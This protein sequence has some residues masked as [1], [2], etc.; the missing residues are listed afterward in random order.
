M[1]SRA[2]QI[3]FRCQTYQRVQPNTFLTFVIQ[4]FLLY[5]YQASLSVGIKWVNR[6]KLLRRYQTHSM[7]YN[8]YHGTASFLFCSYLLLLS[9]FFYYYSYISIHCGAINADIYIIHVLSQV[10]F[11]LDLDFVS[12]FEWRKHKPCEGSGNWLLYAAAWWD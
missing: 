4:F 3:K 6:S 11:Q 1:G 8:H 7:C 5:S 2:V 9:F 12:K 10:L